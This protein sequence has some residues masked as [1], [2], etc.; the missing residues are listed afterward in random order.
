MMDRRRD[1][2]LLLLGVTLAVAAQADPTGERRALRIASPPP[3]ERDAFMR[4]PSTT[5]ADLA[6]RLEAD[7]KLLNAYAKHFGVDAKRIPAFVKDAL[8]LRPLPKAQAVITYGR[9]ISGEVY[10]VR[11]MLPKGSQVWMTR[12]GKAWL[13]WKCTN[14]LGK[15]LPIMPM[16]PREGSGS[17]AFQLDISRP[18][19]ALSVLPES[20]SAAT[21]LNLPVPSDPPILLESP[22]K[23][24]PYNILPLGLVAEPE[25][26]SRKN[27]SPWLWAIGATLPRGDR[28]TTMIPE[29][30]SAALLVLGGFGLLP[31]LLRRKSKH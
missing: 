12:D 18:A 17:E 28:T 7:P 27:V 25:R 16:S 14:P 3:G 29:P 26:T 9:R 24:A 19:G 15:D 11:Q 31:F 21:V 23:P 6:R 1:I 8:V 4:V 22:Y 13:K 10:P 2:F 5:A 20:Q 30:S